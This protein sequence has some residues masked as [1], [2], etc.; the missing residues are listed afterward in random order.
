MNILTLLAAESEG[1]GLG[2]LGFGK[3]DVPIGEAAVYALIGLIIVIAVL[4]LLVGIFY[5]SGMLFK[6]KLF[7]KTKKDE[8]K[9]V[10]AQASDDEENDEELLAVITAAISAAIDSESQDGEAKPEFVIRRIK[11]KQ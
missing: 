11:R 1:G 6:S 9:V 5:L 7:D 2:N 8:K 10:S 4:A 3:S